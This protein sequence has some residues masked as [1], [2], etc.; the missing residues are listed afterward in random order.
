LVTDG[1]QR[2]ALA[3]VRALGGNGY[4]VYVCAKRLPSLAG[5]SRFA[6]AQSQVP[7][8]LT[9]PGDLTTAL[10]DLVKRWRIR[11]LIPVTEPTLLAV[12]GAREMFPDVCIPFPDLATFRRISDKAK[13]LRAADETGIATPR[14]YVLEDLAAASRLDM[15]SLPFPIVLKPGRSVGETS[16][17]RAK[18]NVSYANDRIDLERKLLALPEQ[19]FPLL[20][21]QRIEGPGVGIFLLLWQGKSIASFAHRRIREKPPS[22]GV[23]V[24]RESITADPALVRLSTELLRRFR[25]Q[26]VAMV[27]YKIDAAS[28]VPF[29]MEVNGRFW[30]SL[31][32]ALDAG[33]DFPGLLLAAA[34]GE[35]LEPQH[36]YR[37]GV[38]SRWWWGDV[39]QLLARLRHSAAE[40]ALPSDASTRLKSLL[41][42]LV[43]WRPGDRNE[44]LRRDD[45]APFLRESLDWFARR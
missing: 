40:L 23:S 14:Q 19:A 45:P 12:L 38:R 6:V 2:A 1:D 13:L 25:W 17:G 10:V 7:D 37:V 29:L 18:L 26:G 15:D 22:G 8:G 28:G 9:D 4:S 35:A 11:V 32:L 20:L 5:A 21:Q 39:D 33:V 27:E 44:I 24:Y 34:T 43:L 41:Q 3:L 31:Q 16:A 30:G 36:A 42:F